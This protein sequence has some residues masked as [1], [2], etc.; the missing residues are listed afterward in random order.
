VDNVQYLRNHITTYANHPNQ[1]R[2]RGRV[3]A[4]TF[5]GQTCNFGQ[6]FV[7]EGWVT[8]FVHH[9]ELT[10]QNAIF[11]PSFID[12]QTSNQFAQVMDGDFNVCASLPP[13]SIISLIC[14]CN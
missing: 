10:G 1:F 8:Q 4:S 14:P 3:F 11:V 12:P 9:P 7:P 6:G 5:T 2:Y 13:P